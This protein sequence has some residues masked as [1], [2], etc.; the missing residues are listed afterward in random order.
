[1]YGIAL[2]E[3]P[4]DWSVLQQRD[5]MAK[6]HLSGSFS[7]HPAALQV[8][9][10]QVTPCYRVMREE[11][12]LPVIP[13]TPMTAVQLADSVHFCGSFE[14]EI[15]LPVG[16]PF[17]I[18]TTL[19]TKST[20]QSLTWLYRGDVSLHLLVGDVFVIAGQS[21]SAG[22]AWDTCPDPPHLCVHVFRNRCRWDLA[23]H[24]L[25]DSTDAGNPPN[26]EMGIPGISPYLSFGK[27]Y[28]ALT[29]HPVGLIQT[30]LGGSA[31]AQWNP[32]TGPLYQNM[33][34]RIRLTGQKPAGVLWYQGCNDTDNGETEQYLSDFQAMVLHL[35]RDLGYPIPIFTMQL[36]RQIGG[37]SDLG[38]AKIREAQRRAA[39]AIPDVHILTTTNLPLSDSLHNSAAANLVLGEKL[40]MQAARYLAGAQVPDFIP[41]EFE[42]AALLSGEALA[43][44]RLEGIWLMLRFRHVSSWFVLYSQRGEESG[45]TLEDAEGEIP[46]LTIR[47]DVQ[48]RNHVFLRLQ[49]KPQKNSV[50]SFC[51]QADPVRFPLVDAVTY[52]PPVSFYQVPILDAEG[53]ENE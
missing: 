24:P 32:E 23:T 6:A 5:G 35:R 29:R 45:F 49:R 34:E 7:V 15:A 43:E 50:L 18:E 2:R 16:G 13:W 46:I 27:K 10:E 42:S 47:A 25:N 9:V 20:Q 52:L 31:I 1:M 39:A 30:A 14:T 48:D 36:N 8:G 21:N 44:R 40:A 17:R 19:L 33:L 37:G 3:R 11:D 4:D 53:L 12:N 22:H 51:W 28:Y 41:P 38:W 26:E